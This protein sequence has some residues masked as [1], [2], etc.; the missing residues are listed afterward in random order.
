MGLSYK[1]L[2]IKILSEKNTPLKVSEIWKIAE[3][4]GY[5]RKLNV[6]NPKEKSLW[7]TLDQSVGKDEGVFIC[8]GYPKKYRI[9]ARFLKKYEKEGQIDEKLTARKFLNISE[10]NERTDVLAELNWSDADNKEML[11]CYR[12]ENYSDC[13]KC[14]SYNGKGVYALLRKSKDRLK[15]SYIGISL[16]ETIKRVSDHHEKPTSMF[17]IAKVLVRN[18]NITKR[19]LEAIERV[20]IYTMRPSMNIN[21]KNH[22][23][24]LDII[25]YNRS[26]D[27]LFPKRIEVRNGELISEKWN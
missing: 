3:K 27:S 13:Y 1:E 17:K 12:C 19:R 20:L 15:V 8:S 7:V 4:R 16:V 11:Y 9:S 26:Q 22:L 2:A 21:K 14:E 10:V 25:V 5:D 24:D 18:G 6:I 23:P